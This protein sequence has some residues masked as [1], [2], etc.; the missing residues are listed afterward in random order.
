MVPPHCFI[1]HVFFVFICSESF[2]RLAW[3]VENFEVRRNQLRDAPFWF[4]QILSYYN[5][6]YYL[7][8]KRHVYNISE[9]NVL[10]LMDQF[11]EKPH[12]RTLKILSIFLLYLLHLFWKFSSVCRKWLRSLNL[13]GSVWWGPPFW[14]PKVLSEFI[15]SSSCLCWKFHV[16]SLSGWKVR[17]LA[18][19]FEENLQFGTFK[20]CQILS[21]LCVCIP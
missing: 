14:Y 13:G 5:F 7:S 4:L 1:F 12:G 19:P 10:I 17:I 9:W 18:A 6:L 11:R 8:W 21:F 20:F 15:F 3:M 16:S 2:M